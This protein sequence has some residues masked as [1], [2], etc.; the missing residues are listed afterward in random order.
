MGSKQCCC[1]CCLLFLGLFFIGIA[2]LFVF[3][4]K[5]GPSLEASYKVTDAALTQF[6]T[7]S[8]KTLEYNLVA[9]ITVENREKNFD[10][11]YDKF[12]AVAT[13]DD[14]DLSAVSLSTFDVAS[15]KTSAVTPLVFKGQ[16]SFKGDVASKI[17]GG[18]SFDI[19]LKIKIKVLSRFTKVDIF[20]EYKV[21]C[22]LKVPLINSKGKSSD[23]FESTDCEKV[24][25]CLLLFPFLTFECYDQQA[26]NKKCRNWL[27]TGANLKIVEKYVLQIS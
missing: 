16:K 17:K 11:K 15:T 26:I 5:L 20:N 12:E 18:T 13:Y 19:V 3:R 4:D 8:G 6:G 23:K 7:G 10:Y 2:V 22:K 27:V 25:I 14:K 21:E 9:N 1:C 24:C